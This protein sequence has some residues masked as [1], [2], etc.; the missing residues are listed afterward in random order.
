[1]K[2]EL[3]NL[4]IDFGFKELF[5]RNGREDIV[6]GFLNGM[7]EECLEW[8]IGCVQLE[9]ADLEREYEED[10]LCILEI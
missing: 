10:K 9:D 6:I 4:R 2:E 3:V 1:M 5:G 7:L 8:G